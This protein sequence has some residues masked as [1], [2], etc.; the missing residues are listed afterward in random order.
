MAKWH[1]LTKTATGLSMVF[2][3]VAKSIYPRWVQNWAYCVQ[4]WAYK[5]PL[6]FSYIEFDT[7]FFVDTCKEC[8]CCFYLDTSTPFCRILAASICPGAHE[9]C[10]L[11][12][13]FANDGSWKDGLV[14]YIL[15]QL[16]NQSNAATSYAKTYDEKRNKSQLPPPRQVQVWSKGWFV[17]RPF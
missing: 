7:V 13:H 2:S 12:G 1:M 16:V 8:K 3:D 14:P 6:H 9:P 11:F 15:R 10:E 4:N 17:W 5:I